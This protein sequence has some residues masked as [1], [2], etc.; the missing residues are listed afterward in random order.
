MQIETRAQDDDQ[1]S[2]RCQEIAARVRRS[3]APP[4]HSN[5][6]ACTANEPRFDSLAAAQRDRCRPNCST[7]PAPSLVTAPRAKERPSL[8]LSAALLG[9]DYTTRRRRTRGL[10]APGRASQANPL[11]RPGA[12]RVRPRPSKGRRSDSADCPRART[13]RSCR[14]RR[15]DSRDWASSRAEAE[16]NRPRAARALSRGGSCRSDLWCSDEGSS[17]CGALAFMMQ[18]CGG[19]L[20]AQL[21]GRA[22]LPPGTEFAHGPA[23]QPPSQHR[24]RASPD[25]CF[26]AR[27]RG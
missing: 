13:K 4:A 24:W 15:A 2:H 16:A 12:R 5:A 10:S 8:R 21:S 23:I 27:W 18:S 7:S 1:Q 9:E 14:A 6:T 20:R 25:L 3:A 26:R 22:R 19:E 17:N 11:V